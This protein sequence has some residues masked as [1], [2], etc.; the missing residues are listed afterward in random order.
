MA[1]HRK[2]V[3]RQQ[4]VELRETGVPMKQIAK[5]FGCSYT[6]LYY[7]LTGS[8]GPER[9]RTNRGTCLV[10]WC[11]RACKS[12]MDVCHMHIPERVC[13]IANCYSKRYGEWSMCKGHFKETLFRQLEPFNYDLVHAA[14]YFD[15]PW[16]AHYLDNKGYVRVNFW[17]LTAFEHRVE[18]ARK[19]GRPLLANENVHHING[20]RD[21]NRHENLELWVVSQPSGQRAE[22]LLAWADEILKTYGDAA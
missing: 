1:N 22:D 5:Q 4:I 2:D 13:G 17:G 11:S 12:G 3:S 7:R 9:Q 18:L 14:L 10:P 6:T 8:T 20:K 16:T 19:L 21:D 15:I